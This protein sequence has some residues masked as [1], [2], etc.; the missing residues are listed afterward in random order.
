M[1]IVA[2]DDGAMMI[3]GLARFASGHPDSTPAGVERLGRVDGYYEVMPDHPHRHRYNF[4]R[5]NRWGTKGVVD[6]DS[7]IAPVY[8][9]SRPLTDDER[10][11]MAPKEGEEEAEAC[12]TVL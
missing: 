8:R 3:D 1:R 11:S 4:S 12:C 6:E 10:A 7:T 5:T 9:R 2:A